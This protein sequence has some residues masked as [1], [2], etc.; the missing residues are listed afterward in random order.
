MAAS[1]KTYRELADELGSSL[2]GQAPY[3]LGV[4][5][6]AVSRALKRDNPRFDEDRFSYA[7]E[8]AAIKAWPAVW[9]P[10]MT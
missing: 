3:E 6:G 9:R 2:L 7:V 8:V 5:V 1:R 4:A 10:D